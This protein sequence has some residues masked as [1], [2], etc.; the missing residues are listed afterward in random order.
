MNPLLKSSL[1]TLVLVLTFIVGWELYWRNQNLGLSFN[2]DESLW[3]HTRKE[4]YH[5][6]PSR[7]VIIGSSRVKFG[8]D[9]ATWEAATG[10]KPIQLALVGTAPRPLLTDLAND[11]NFK[12]TL[13]IGVTEGLFFTPD[14]SFPEREATKRVDF[15]P[16]WSLSQQISFHINRVLEPRLCFLDEQRLA[17]R[18][19]LTNLPI[20]P[21]PGTWGGP[22]FPREFSVTTFDRQ[23]V[24]TDAMVADTAIQHQVQAV[25]LDIGAHSPKQTMPDAML[26]GIL[27]SVKK[28]IDQIRARG[29]QVVFVR[30]PSDGP[31]YEVE[32]MSHPREK[33]WDR[34]LSHTRTPGIYFAD[35]P[36]L[37]KY[38]CPEWSHLTPKDA[39]TFT[40]D[41]IPILQQKTGWPITIRPTKKPA[42]TASI[43]LHQ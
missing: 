42:L 12:G 18:P 37:S 25:W 15:Y 31:F 6:S 24:M 38:R 10:E 32:K 22:K 1:L 41:F 16:K 28:S 14:G 17:L 20:P 34:L 36:A 11:P 4:I 3:A 21:R 5:S 26:T 27:N 19:L 40:Q 2:D 7:P 43:P 33:Y 29:G 39:V 9:L 13:I 23:D 30:M 35:Y 8:I